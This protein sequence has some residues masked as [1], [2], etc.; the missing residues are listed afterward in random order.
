MYCV[1][2]LRHTGNQGKQHHQKAQHYGALPGFG[3][4]MPV[5]SLEREKRNISI[6]NTDS[7]LSMLLLMVVTLVYSIKVSTTALTHTH[8]GSSKASTAPCGRYFCR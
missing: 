6:P 7:T 3:F 1:H 8:K 2:P 5:K 4:R